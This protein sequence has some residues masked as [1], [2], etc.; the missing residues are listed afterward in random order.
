MLCIQGLPL[1]NAEVPKPYGNFV[2]TCRVLMGGRNRLRLH[3]VIQGWVI[4][5]AVLEKNIRRRVFEQIVDL[6]GLDKDV[7]WLNI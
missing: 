1:T 5:A 6:R 3:I 4:W 2:G 7:L